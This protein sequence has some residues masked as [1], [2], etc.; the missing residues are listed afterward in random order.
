MPVSKRTR[1]EVLRRD[2]HTCRYCHATDQ[3]LTVD[4]VTPVALGGTDDPSNLVACCKDCNAGKSSTTP[5][6]ALVADVREDAVRHAE[7]I[8]QSYVVLVERMGKRDE[9]V[10]EWR[11]SWDRVGLPRDW[12]N[13]INRWFEMGV[14][15]ELI[16]DAAEIA[17]T[18]TTVRDDG[19]FSYMCGIV[20]SQVKMVDE[21]AEAYRHVEGSF[22]GEDAL[23]DRD[24]EKYTWGIRVGRKTASQ[25]IG[26]MDVVGIVIDGRYHPEVAGWCIAD[27]THSRTNHGG[28]LERRRVHRHEAT[29]P[30]GCYMFLLSQP[31]LVHAGLVPMRVNRWAKKS[32]DAT[33]ASIRA[34]WATSP[35]TGSSSPTTTPRK[36]LMRTM[37]RNDGVYKQPKVM[38]SACARTPSRS[39]RPLL[40]HAFEPS[41]TA[42]PLDELSDD[43]DRG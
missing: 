11:E 12:R 15:I 24:Y 14:P 28:D 36:C 23:I 1:Y 19:R 8:R 25:D 38:L 4:H 31:D 27:A 32:A 30:S 40:R 20:W 7:L 5:D 2:N 18:R 42:L 22:M 34:T 13:T 9:Y 35:P 43:C 26:R 10:D 39:S 21:L 41:W 6:S 29:A 33:A 16:Q 37:V 3:P 17:C